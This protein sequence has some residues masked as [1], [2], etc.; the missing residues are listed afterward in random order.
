VGAIHRNGGIS[1]INLK[2]LTYFNSN[3]NRLHSNSKD[4]SGGHCPH[5]AMASPS[6]GRGRRALGH[7]TK[8]RE[9]GGGLASTILY[10]RYDSMSFFL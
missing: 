3:M 6:K 8:E 10:N 4:L 1:S 2:I 5:S 9:R 7:Y